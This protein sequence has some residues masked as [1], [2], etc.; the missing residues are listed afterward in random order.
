MIWALII[1]SV[2]YWLAVA[3]DVVTTRRAITEGRGVEGNERYV[4]PDGSVLY[5]R[6]LVDSLVTWGVGAAT[7]IVVPLP[8]AVVGLVWIA[9]RAGFRLARAVSNHNLGRTAR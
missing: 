6:N 7:A 1:T 4:G 2:V 9:V 8:F 5:G 3:A